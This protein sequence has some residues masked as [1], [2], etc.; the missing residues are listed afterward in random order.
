MRSLLSTGGGAGR[1]PVRAPA[2]RVSRPSRT[3]PTRTAKRD[4]EATESG[5]EDVVGAVDGGMAQAGHA[6]ASMLGV[7]AIGIDVSALNQI[8]RS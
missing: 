2:C 4:D 5:R 1:S 3:P 6:A 8:E 7:N